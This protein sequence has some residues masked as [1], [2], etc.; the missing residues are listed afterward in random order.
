MCKTFG[1]LF[2]DASFRHELLSVDKKQ[3]TDAVMKRAE[4]LSNQLVCKEDSA[5]ETLEKQVIITL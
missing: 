4:Y 1:T 2:A 3:F 5:N